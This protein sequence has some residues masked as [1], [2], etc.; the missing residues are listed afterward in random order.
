MGVSAGGSRLGVLDSIWAEPSGVIMAF[1]R[2][3]HAERQGGSTVG[4]G[5]K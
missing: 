4:V 2:N 1:G 3:G 5:R